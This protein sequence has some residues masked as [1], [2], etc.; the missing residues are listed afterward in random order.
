MSLMVFLALLFVFFC[1]VTWLLRGN[2]DESRQDIAGFKNQGNVDVVLVGGSS[3]LRFYNPLQA[4]HDYGI[5]SYNYATTGAKFDVLKDYI[6]ESRKSNEAKLY[7]INVRTIAML[8]QELD[9]PSIRNWSDSLS[10]LS[11]TRIQGINNYVFARDWEDADLPSFYFDI[12]KYHTNYNALYSKEQWSYL[13]YGSL[14]CVDKGFAPNLGRI[15]FEKRGWGYS[16]QPLSD[17]QKNALINI[18][19]YCD[20]EKLQALFI[21]CPYIYSDYDEG[22]I[23]S[24]GDVI[25]SRGYSYINFNEFCEKIGIDFDRDFSDINHVNY[26][27]SIKYTDYLAKY[28]TNKYQLTDH[29][30]DDSYDQWNTD[31][32]TAQKKM[33][34]ADAELSRYILGQDEARELG[35]SLS[36]EEDFIEWLFDIQN[37][38]F[39]VAIRINNL[40]QYASQKDSLSLFLK[41]Y[42]IDSSKDNYAGIWVGDMS[43]VSSTIDDMVQSE[44]GVNGGVKKDN[45]IVS[46]ED[47]LISI[48]G[49][50]YT[51]KEGTIQVLVYDNNYQEVIDN[52]NIGFDSEDKIILIRPNGKE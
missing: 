52:V 43:L 35:I 19:D 26:Y 23:N 9:E 41:T 49:V 25:R 11:L 36:D 51:A 2:S 33:E 42:S 21:C 38:H 12:I 14:Y 40:T 1:K 5:T 28:I 6:I 34:I 18:L 37:Q 7:V 27:G 30:Y 17:Q 8:T 24:C 3:L 4:W 13:Q 39:T 16:R 31:Y 32:F 45:C 48:G 22:I 50:D 15:P 44:I 20:K 46:T 47:C 29:R 10:P